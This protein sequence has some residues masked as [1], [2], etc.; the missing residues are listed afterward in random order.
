MAA[1][2]VNGIL[3][4]NISRSVE[5]GFGPFGTYIEYVVGGKQAMPIDSGL[6]YERRTSSMKWQ[7]N[8]NWMRA[9]AGSD[10]EWSWARSNTS[11]SQ[12]LARNQA[13]ES[14][15]SKILNTAQLGASI[16]EYSQASAMISARAQQLLRFSRAVRRLDLP[17]AA[18]ALSLDPSN[19]KV[20]GSDRFGRTKT[21]GNLFLEYHFG[22]EPLAKDIIDGCVT[23][24]TPAKRLWAKGR[25]SSE[26]SS[27]VTTSDHN[28]IGSGGTS[29]IRK[30]TWV[31]TMSA[32]CVINNP[33][34]AVNAQ[35]GLLNPLSIAWE[36]V[37][38]SFVVDWFV[39]VGQVLSSMTDF[40][41]CTISNSWHSDTAK[42][43]T[44]LHQWWVEPTG[45]W[46]GLASGNSVDMVR[47]SGLVSPVIVARPLKVPS[48]TR[49]ATQVSLLTQFLGKQ[50]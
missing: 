50:H 48:I 11:S 5:T 42:W 37:P 24:A 49:A 10:V 38:F 34:V 28:S 44:E 25:G 20:R 41:G 31:S 45:M 17:S 21:F 43:S 27:V 35:L 40:M 29:R 26:I 46:Y 16:A 12:A 1:P 8:T 13:Y 47:S 18:R 36:L 2:Y 33:N 7:G 39:N 4:T 32:C 9:G 23:L 30:G 19:R 15:K 6:P 14:V 22:W 3:R